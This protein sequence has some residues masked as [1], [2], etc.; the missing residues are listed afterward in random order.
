MNPHSKA[1][2]DY[3]QASLADASRLSP[4]FG[5]DRTVEVQMDLL[6]DGKVG[7]H[8]TKTLFAHAKKAANGSIDDE[9][10]WPIPVLVC[11]R[12]FA[13]RAEHGYVS[14]RLPSKIAPIVIYAKL[15]QDGQLIDDE[16]ANASVLMP[17]NLLEP[18]P[19]EV[20]LG[21]VEGADTAYA[22]YNDQRGSWSALV[23]Q[24]EALTFALTGQTL[25]EL[26][27]DDYV[28]LDCGHLWLRGPSPATAA[29]EAL[30]DRLRSPD[31]PDVQLYETLTRKAG[32]QRLLTASEQLAATIDHLGQMECRYGLADSQ[33][34]SL[35]HYLAGKAPS[36]LTVDGPPGTGKT[37]LLLSVIATEWVKAALAG[38]EPPLIVAA[39]TNNQAVLNIL[40][41]FAEVKEPTD[42]LAGRWLPEL[43]SYGLFLPSQTAKIEKSFKVHA[44]KGMGK[45]AQY[46]AQA[47]ET[48]AGFTTAR[49]A[50]LAKARAAFAEETIN[51]LDAV[52]KLLAGKLQEVASSIRSAVKALQLLHEHVGEQGLSSADTS[53]AR[54]ALQADV[55][56]LEAK[57]AKA[58]ADESE[59]RSLYRQWH[60]HCAAERWWMALLAGIGILGMRRRRDLAF[61]AD[62]EAE[63][64][65]LLGKRF[66][67]HPERDE[68]DRA[69]RAMLD[70]GEDTRETVGAAL[71]EHRQRLVR[72]DQAVQELRRLVPEPE[73]LTFANAQAALDI[74]PRFA[75]FKLATHYWEVRY[76]TEVSESLGRAGKMEDNKAPEKLL[77]QYRR[78][79]KLFPCFVSTLFTLPGR[80]EG[81]RGKPKPLYNAIDL[82]IVDEAGQVSP[83]IGAPSFSLAQRA[84]VVGDVDQIKPVWSVPRSLDLTNAAQCGLIPAFAEE[85]DFLAAGIAAS[86]G[87]LMQLGQRATPFSKHPLRGRGMFLCEHRRCWPEIIG[88]SNR[89]AYQGLLQPCRE[90]GPRKLVPTLGYVHLPGL[91]QKRGSSRRNLLEATAIAKWLAQ[92]KTEIEDAFK[93][94]DKAFGQLV[95]VITPFAAQVHAI[96]RALDDAFGKG[97]DITVGTV[98]ALQGAEQR[99]VIFSPTCGLEAEPG[100][101]F[102]DRDPSI[103]N[104]AVSRAQDAFLVFGNMHLFRPVGEHPSAI[105]GRAL[106]MGGQNEITDVP[107]DLLAPGF[108]L[109]PVALIRDLADHR[110]ALVEAFQTAR[111][112]LV[113]VSP[114][115]TMA[116][117]QADDILALITK[118][119]ARGV[120]VTIVTDPSLNQQKVPEFNHC[121]EQLSTAGAVI[122]KASP[123]GVHSKLILVDLA[124]LIVGSF[125]WLSA[126]RS[127]A[128]PYA[129]YESS[130]RYDGAEAFEMI[131]RTLGDLKALIGEA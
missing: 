57:L 97:H 117:I 22:R 36:V 123:Q 98:F 52:R 59:A 101:T 28:P 78:L 107:A 113:V 18:T 11:P 27:I 111:T 114:F 128:S 85:T 64:A 34:E 58:S 41:A 121:I 2:L 68:V 112:R 12:V 96:R 119:S 1:Y 110:S 15:R 63:H 100:R 9:R 35:A 42:A 44:M 118:A 56:A 88:I 80:F 67:F 75:A 116:A 38:G 66:R 86:A 6:P 55:A 102:F 31:A 92:R 45:E 109:S 39:S 48:D 122:H 77:R 83:E 93:E 40:R 25:A 32:D 104:V 50:L 129:R 14:D 65:A 103:L 126:V 124:W 23:T 74:G 72:F 16:K 3:L 5:S 47:Y 79:A 81:F 10:L 46:E 130:L 26:A 125:N 19:W 131:G 29:I 94:D 99:V 20:T 43:A 13:L 33:R 95:A 84:L 21:T 17:R 30:V 71:G 70:T 8:A 54:K 7:E 61:L 106:F 73:V 89:L 53:G 37:T 105:V 76:L 62:A 91:S 87:S 115:L 108:D 82:L 90:E 51:D 69:L 127:P 120:R 60:H 49:D 4:S 24:A